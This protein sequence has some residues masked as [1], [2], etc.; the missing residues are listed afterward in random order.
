MVFP[1]LSK[2]FDGTLSVFTTNGTGLADLFDDAID[3]MIDVDG[4]IP[5][6]KSNIDRRVRDLNDQIT[7]QNKRVDSYEDRLQAQFLAME[8]AISQLN[9][10]SSY[11]QSQLL[12]F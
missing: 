1:S 5:S 6:Q 2:D 9:N 7:R 10:Q 11:L 3:N 12:A 4:L 8:Q